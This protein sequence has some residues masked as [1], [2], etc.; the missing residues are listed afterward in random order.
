[1]GIIAHNIHV[2]YHGERRIVNTGKCIVALGPHLLGTGS[3]D[4]F[5]IKHNLLPPVS[6]HS[7]AY[8]KLSIRFDFASVISRSIGFCAP[9]ITI[10]FFVFS[11]PYRKAPLPCTPSYLS[12]G[13][14][15]SVKIV[16][17]LPNR[18]NMRFRDDG[19]HVGA[20]PDLK[21]EPPRHRRSLLPAEYTRSAPPV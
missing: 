3:G 11:A 19:V 17:V 18:M 15:E 5:S 8:K 13:Q 12:H 16:V 6:G 1:M 10:G 7:A 21:A 2:L 20:C 14:Y 9:V 4:D